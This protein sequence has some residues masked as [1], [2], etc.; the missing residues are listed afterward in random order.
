[1]ARAWLVAAAL[2]VGCAA[3]PAV[4]PTDVLPDR[5]GDV[6]RRAGE[7]DPGGAAD[8]AGAAVELPLTSASYGSRW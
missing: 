4:G 8:V 7:A 1:M 6:R 5:P 3:T 2:A